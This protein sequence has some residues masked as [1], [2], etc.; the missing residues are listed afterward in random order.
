MHSQHI[1]LADLHVSPLNMRAEKKE[2]SLQRMAVIAAD[3]LPSIREKGILQDLIVRPNGQGFEIVAGRRR[4]YGA[5]VV[6]QERGDFGPL[7]CRV[8][9]EGDDAE[10]LEISLIENVA[11]EDVDPLSQYEN[12]ARLIRLGRSPAQIALSFGIG[13]KE[14]RQRLALA[15]L[16][17]RLRDAYRAEL[18]NAGE[19]QILTLAGK[20]QQRAFLALLDEHNAPRGSHLRDWLFGGDAISTKHALFSLEDYKGEIVTDL[21][22]EDGFF[23]D[24]DAFWELQDQAIA[25]RRDAYLD[26]NWAEVVI[27]ERGARFDTWNFARAKKSASGRVYIAAAA[28]GEVTFH[29]GYISHVEARKALSKAQQGKDGG[30]PVDRA[31]AKSPV[32]NKMRNYI[33]LHQHAAARLS[34]LSNPDMALRMLV[35][36]AV[37]STGNW[38]VKPDTQRS[39]GNDV[40]ASL[41]ASEAQRLFEAERESVAALLGPLGGEK[42][43]P[44]DIGQPSPVSGQCVG[45]AAHTVRVFE[46]LGALA[47]E[48]FLRVAAFVMAETLATGSAAARA[49]GLAAKIDMRAHW[50][51]DEA[52]FNLVRDRDSLNAM[53]AEVAGKKEARKHVTAKAKDQRAALARAAAAE[54]AWCPGWMQFERTDR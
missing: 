50:A 28:S 29:E 3:L 6:E 15:N 5:R 30:E 41:L 8:M 52:F 49:I 20:S 43:V 4:Y 24:K 25:A 33:D 23:K 40:K 42:E 9:G 17:P 19:M 36:H 2:P 10:A 35:A 32:T 45:E 48:E 44:D 7:S 26:A 54:P 53:L 12:Y 14:V 51:P 47:P 22:G 21:F 39:D 34:L 11:R 1:Q 46:R 38:S 31:T 18:I 16:L 27:L 13:E 37:A